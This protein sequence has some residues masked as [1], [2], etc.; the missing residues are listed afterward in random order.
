MDCVDV[1]NLS[2][3]DSVLTKRSM[4]CPGQE[5]E[6]LDAIGLGWVSRIEEVERG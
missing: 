1:P 6:D 2:F 4:A 5:T 3:L